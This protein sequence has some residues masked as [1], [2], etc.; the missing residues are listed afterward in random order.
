MTCAPSNLRP[1][2]IAAVEDIQRAYRE[3]AQSVLLQ[4]PTGAGKTHL[5]ARGIIAPSVARGR[6]VAFVADLEEIVEDTA[7]RLRAEGLRVG[8][9]QSGRTQDPDALVQVCSLQ[10]LARYSERGDALP[11]ADRVILDEAHVASARTAREILSTYKGR[12]ALVLGLTATPARGD[13]QP[14]DE[15]ERLITGPSMRQLITMDA[16]VPCEVMAPP[17]VLDRGVCED[18]VQAVLTRAPERRCV[19]FAPDAAQAVRIADEL[20]AQGHNTVA[21]LDSTHK[22]ARRTVRQ[23]LLDGSVRSLVTVRALQ[24]G[25]DAPVLDCAV[26]T[27]HGTI[28]TYL[29]SIGRALRTYPGKVNARVLDLRGA[30][31]LHGLPE[32]DRQWSLEGTQGAAQ[33]ERLTSL[34]RCNQCH[35]VFPARKVC[36]RCGSVHV[37]DPRP[38]RVQRAEMFAASEMPPRVRAEKYVDGTVRAMVLRGMPAHVAARKAREKAPQWVKSALSDSAGQER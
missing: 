19:I 12:G 21:V 24:K 32:E 25:F 5:G 8:I 1:Y 22:D 13:G 4:L 35:A 38:L 20:S 30:V 7:G 16:I 34:R 37:V 14:L 15:F 17:R 3:G 10:T 27:T 26:L 11:V 36:P 6:R 18:P 23:R 9:V 2:Q 33:G 31:Y 29:Q 28:T